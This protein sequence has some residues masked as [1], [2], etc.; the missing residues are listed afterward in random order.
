MEV[1]GVELV[2]VRAVVVWG[3]AQ[4]SPYPRNGKP[5]N[6][7][8]HRIKART[9][10]EHGMDPRRAPRVGKEAKSPQEKWKK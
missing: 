2:V 6:Y 10:G 7:I 1:C 5:W 4:D 8:S 3:S 9:K